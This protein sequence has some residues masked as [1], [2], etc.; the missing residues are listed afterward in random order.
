MTVRDRTDVAVL[1][2]DFIAMDGKRNKAKKMAKRGPEVSLLS[3]G[4]IPETHFTSRTES[5][6]LPHTFLARA[7][8]PCAASTTPHTMAAASL[9]GSSEVPAPP[10]L[11]PT[12]PAAARYQEETGKEADEDNLPDIK[13]LLFPDPISPQAQGVERSYE[14]LGRPLLLVRTGLSSARSLDGHFSR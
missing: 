7:A 4:A 11:G 3:G 14:R 5:C 1:Q 2:A 10:S 8:R 12:S 6:I 9:S 13:E